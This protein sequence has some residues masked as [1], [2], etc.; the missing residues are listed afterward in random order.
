MPP[1]LTV[2]WQVLQQRAPDLAQQSRRVGWLSGRIG[3]L[4]GLDPATVAAV[5]LAGQF[6]AVGLLA[7]PVAW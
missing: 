1:Q 2:L 7:L 3:D 6:Y 4:A 5:Q